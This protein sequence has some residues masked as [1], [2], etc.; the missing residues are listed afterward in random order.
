LFTENYWLIITKF[1]GKVAH[2]PRNKPLFF[3]LI[4]CLY[5]YTQHWTTI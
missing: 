3:F 5:C 2:W 4:L 1:D